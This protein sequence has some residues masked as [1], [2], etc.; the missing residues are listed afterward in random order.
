M[1]QESA[2]DTL[3][4]Q[5]VAMLSVGALVAGLFGAGVI[6]RHHS[7]AALAAVAIA[8]AFF[9]VSAILA[10]TVIWPRDWDGFEHDMRPNLDEIDQGDLVDMLALTTSWARMYECA[11]AANQCKM[12][13]LT[14][15]FTAICGLVAAQVICWGL[16]IL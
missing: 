16:A 7:H 8:I 6:P 11:R 12:K 2:L 10:V 5:T 15:A 13:W 4:T 9:G 1:R 3:R 14:R